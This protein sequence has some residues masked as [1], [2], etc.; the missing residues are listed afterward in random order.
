MKGVGKMRLKRKMRLKQKMR[1]EHWYYCLIY[2]FIMSLVVTGVSFSRFS[3]VLNNTGAEN[4]GSPGPGPTTPDI[5]F[6]TWAIDYEAVTFNLGN[7]APGDTK[8]IAI[9]IK[10][11]NSAGQISGY[12]QNVTLELRTTGNLPLSYTLQ[13][14]GGTPVAFNHPDTYRYVSESQ[15]FTANT[16]ETKGYILTIS[17]PGGSND[18]KYRNELDYIE[19]K[20]KAVQA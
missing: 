9:W 1:L 17:W 4:I 6:S 7:M 13:K 15:A 18:Y 19:L 16:E 11:K 10:N 3:S 5:E 2:L 20:L 14:D 8:T 12:N